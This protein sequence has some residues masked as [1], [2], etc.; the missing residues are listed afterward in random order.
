MYMK[1]TLLP[2]DAV[3]I[4]FVVRYQNASLD[5]VMFSFLVIV[6]T[7]LSLYKAALIPLNVHDLLKYVLSIWSL[8]FYHK[9]V[10]LT[11][12]T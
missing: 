7:Y 2:I 8:N 11:P 3:P 1:N 9:F 12:Y 5:H 4:I 6:L 10:V